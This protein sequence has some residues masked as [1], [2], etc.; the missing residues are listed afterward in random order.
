MTHALK[1]FLVSIA[2]LAVTSPS[3]A[4]P[5]NVA[6]AVSGSSGNYTL[7][8]SFTNSEIGTD[9]DI[10]F[11]GVYLNPSLGL[12]SV[13][14]SPAFYDPSAFP[15][16]TVSGLG[17]SNTE[18]NAVWFDATISNLAAGQTLSG[19]DVHV[20]SAVAPSAAPWFALSTGNIPYTGT[21][22]FTNDPYN[23][24]FEGVAAPEP[25]VWRL[26]VLSFCGF[27]LLGFSCRT[28][29]ILKP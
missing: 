13:V 21:G 2:F 19:F 20:A 15:T 8:F 22:S 7:D 10:Y 29:R 25:A 17:G 3:Y 26:L 4:V 11:L 24:G 18:Y 28:R 14:G 1:T 5:V 12:S 6:Y 23:P 16:Y 9:Q 27:P